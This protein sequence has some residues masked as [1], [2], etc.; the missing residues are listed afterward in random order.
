[1]KMIQVK[2]EIKQG[3]LKIKTPLEMSDGEVD[4]IIFKQSQEAEEF[5]TMRQ[6][7]KENGYDSREKIMDLIHQVKLEMLEEKGRTK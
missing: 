4:L 1:M 7:A 3:E 6:L 2:G 5:Q